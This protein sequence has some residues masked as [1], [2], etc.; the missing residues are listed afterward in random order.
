MAQTALIGGTGLTQMEG[1]SILSREMVKT[2]YG[3][4]SGPLTHGELFGH[5]VTFLA[6]HGAD[7]TIPPHK[8]NYRA[9]IWALRSVGVEQVI[10]IGAVG[11]LASDCGPVAVVIPDQII[12]YTYGREHTFY[13]TLPPGDGHI[14][15]S[16]PYD[17][18]LRQHLIAGARAAGVA[19]VEKGV[20]GITQGPRLETAA[21]IRRMAQDG[22]TIVG[23]TGMPEASLAREAGLGYAA[24]TMVVN[25]AAGLE[26]Q[27][28]NFSEVEDYIQQGSARVRR[29]IEKTFASWAGIESAT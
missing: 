2:P 23:M 19:P 26:P 24:L 22:C 28:I 6:R 25:W 9:N 8:I 3:P 14:G 15:F 16:Y 12:D 7:H 5:E 20:Y 1:L 13:D 11:G 4:P 18:N 21:E 10:A 27:E 17:E 29:V